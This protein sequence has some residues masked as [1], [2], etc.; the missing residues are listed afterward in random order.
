MNKNKNTF[1]SAV[2]NIPEFYQLL[3]DRY[4]SHYKTVLENYIATIDATAQAMSESLALNAQRW[5]STY[6]MDMTENNI[7]FLKAFLSRR[8]ELLNEAWK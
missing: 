5:Y 8:L 3:K 6:P 4:N 2:Y 7:A 1:F